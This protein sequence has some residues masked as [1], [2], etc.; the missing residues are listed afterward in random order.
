MSSFR[1]V[2]TIRRKITGAVDDNGYYQAGNYFKLPIQ[3]SVQ[4][5]NLQEYTA[6]EP[7]GGRTADLVK[8]Y[9][10][11]ELYPIRQEMTENREADV[12][13]WHGRLWRCIRCEAWQSNVISHYK[14]IFREIDSDDESDEEVST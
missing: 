12:L 8:V 4:P 6:Y 10:D 3:A 9:T 1:S 13:E 11:V 2:H 5:V 7:Q 14:A